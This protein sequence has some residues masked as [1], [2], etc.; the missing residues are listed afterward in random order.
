MSEEL[1]K[2]DRLAAEKIMGWRLNGEIE[3][4]SWVGG[5]VELHVGLWW[6]TRNIAQAW[7]LISRLYHLAIRIHNTT[8]GWCAVVGFEMEVEQ[9]APLAIVKACLRAKEEAYGKSPNVE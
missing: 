6:P 5:P 4:S 7:Q 8:G 9:T 1:D 3:T 2:L